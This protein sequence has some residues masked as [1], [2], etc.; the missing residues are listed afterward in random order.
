MT[1]ATK[2][3]SLILSTEYNKILAELTGEGTVAAISGK[4]I[5]DVR[6]ASCHKFKEKLVGPAHFDVLPKYVGNEPKL[7]AFIRNPA[8]S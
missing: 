2:T 3:H 4:E 7:V 1:N 6:C 8:K 5:Y